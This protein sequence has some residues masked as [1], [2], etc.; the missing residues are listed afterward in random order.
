[1]E[2]AHADAR[3]VHV[4]REVLSHL[5]RQSGHQNAL[6]TFGALPNLLQE[7]VDL[8]RRRLHDDLGVDQ[9]RRA[10]D[11]FDKPVRHVFF[12]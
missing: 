6:I 11:L 2:V 12:I 4:I 5:L 3:F 7:I 8:S 1:M 10:D 9:A